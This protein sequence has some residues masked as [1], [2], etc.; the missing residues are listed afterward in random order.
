MAK[1]CPLA[2]LIN[3]LLLFECKVPT[4]ISINHNIILSNIL[5]IQLLQEIYHNHDTITYDFYDMILT[6]DLAVS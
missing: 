4:Y 5:A 3:I 6:C 1:Y 2:K